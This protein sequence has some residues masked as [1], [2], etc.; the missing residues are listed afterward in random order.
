MPLPR[1]C[2]TKQSQKP[3][4]RAKLIISTNQPIGLK[5]TAD[6]FVALSVE[7]TGDRECVEQPRLQSRIT[8]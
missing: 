5:L 2:H 3:T 7:E 4:Q 8:V 6:V 1:A